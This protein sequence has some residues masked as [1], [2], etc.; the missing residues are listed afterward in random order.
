MK[1]LA[2]AFQKS[3]LTSILRSRSVSDEAP[4]GLSSQQTSLRRIMTA[5]TRLGHW[6]VSKPRNRWA[7]NS[8]YVIQS[9]EDFWLNVVELPSDEAKN[10]R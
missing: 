5:P 9:I 10:A 1:I 3:H 2:E 7:W 8:S 6:V 4:R